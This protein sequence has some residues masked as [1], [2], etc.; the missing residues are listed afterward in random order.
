MKKMTA[1]MLIAHGDADRAFELR[2]VDVPV[3]K[4]NE[5]L[6]KVEAFGLNFADVMA[7]RGLYR[8]APPMPA[9]LGYDLVGEVIEA[10]ASHQH[11]VGKRVSGMSRFGAY[12]QYAVTN[13]DAVFEVA[14]HIGAAEA[15][16]IGTQYS[17]AWHAAF[18]ATNMHEG[19]TVLIHAA[20]GGVGTALVQLA[21][22]KNCTIIGTAGS[23]AKIE[24]LKKAG[25]DHPIN[26]REEDYAD[27]IRRQAGRKPLHLSFNAIAGTTFKKDMKLL[28]PGGRL[29]L[30]G[31]AERAGK[32]GGK[33]ATFK[34]LWDMGLMI[35]LVLVGGSRSVIGVNMLRIADYRP[36][37]IREALANLS[38][39]LN[40]G[41][42]QPQSGGEFGI[43]QL[44]EA[45]Q[46]LEERKSTGKIAVKW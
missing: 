41:V 4:E 38:G 34:L 23:D 7:R 46:R 21:K 44:A 31:A 29:I 14:S 13:V 5:L 25:V 10:P 19:D 3:R 22:W 37:L 40:E 11:L 17:T 45:H 27:A 12:A 43:D 2:E 32:K 16:A 26:Y 15:C 6:I 20:A 36:N 39:L 30:Y 9:I 24:L 1:A 33:W 42:I 28:M 35:P 18:Q 8:D